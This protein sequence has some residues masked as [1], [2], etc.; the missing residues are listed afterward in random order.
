MMATKR[1]EEGEN[2]KIGGESN[3]GTMANPALGGRF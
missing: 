2:G 1:H 3:N